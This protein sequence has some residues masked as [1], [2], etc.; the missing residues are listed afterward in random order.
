M[1]RSRVISRALVLVGIILAPGLACAAS[2]RPAERSVGVAIADFAYVDTS[3]EPS[4]QAAAHRRRLQAF[5]AALRRDF[6]A[7]KRYRL[8]SLSCG[9][10]PCT[11]DGTAPSD[12]LR[13]AAE[14]GAK[15]LVVGGIHKQSTLIQ[16]AKLDAIDVGANR[17]L[18]DKL[19]TFRGDSDEAWE[20][21]ET[22]MSREVRAALAPH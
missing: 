12:L 18:L 16:W 3:N 1:L 15:F 14:A 20:R 6:A 7:D 10:S 4:D 13:A 17:V 21:A 5:M 11:E 19:F 9:A 22:F 2:A 8:V